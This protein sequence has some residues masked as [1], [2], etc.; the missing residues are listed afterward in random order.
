MARLDLNYYSAVLRRFI[1]VV[2]YIPND[3][4]GGNGYLPSP[5]KF[6]TL[7]L[8]HGM[9]GGQ[10][11][12]NNFSRVC[13]Y[14]HE[15]D[16]A[17][18]MPDGLNDFYLDTYDESQKYGKF[19]GEE[20]IEYTR[21]LLPLS[22]KRKDTFIGGLSMGGYGALRNGF[23]YADKF[24]NIIALSPAVNIGKVECDQNISKHEMERLFGPFNKI[25][26]TEASIEYLVKHADKKLIPNIYLAIGTAD[27]LYQHVIDFKKFLDKNTI[28]YTY[29]EEEGIGHVWD[30]WDRQIKKGIEWLPTKH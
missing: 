6:K 17:L 21:S 9:Y 11:D 28:K 22:N 27:F 5:K 26:N 4:E 19:I 29:V 14:A 2:C 8:L 3:K 30:F 20:L 25:K 16:I 18:I 15:H 24:S 1:N 12:W 23:R 7:Y 10:E 13:Y